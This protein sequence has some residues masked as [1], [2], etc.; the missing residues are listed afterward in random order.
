MIRFIYMRKQTFFFF[1]FHEL[2][3]FIVIVTR[4]IG[5]GFTCMLFHQPL[6]IRIIDI[7][8]QGPLGPGFYLLAI[9]TESDHIIIIFQPNQKLCWPDDNVLSLPTLQIPDCIQT[10]SV[11]KIEGNQCQKVRTAGGKLIRTCEKQCTHSIQEY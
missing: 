8:H 6:E 4:N 10:N 1:Q 9:A 3:F 7:S 5:G 2:P 11:L